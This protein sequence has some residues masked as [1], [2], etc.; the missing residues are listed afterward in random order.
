[1]QIFQNGSQASEYREV[2]PI[3]TEAIPGCLDP[4]AFN[5]NPDANLNSSSLC[6]YYCAEGTRFDSELSRCD[7]EAWLGE[8]GDTQQLDP[9]YFDFDASGWMDITDLV[10]FAL[11]QDASPGVP[12]APCGAGTFWDADAEVCRPAPSTLGEGNGLGNLNPR[13]FDLNG[14]GTLNTADFLGLLDAFGKPCG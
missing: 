14:D 11:V 7:L 10:R 5:F 6:N 8:T 1:M 9:C 4:V 2:L 13:Y 12:Q 3:L